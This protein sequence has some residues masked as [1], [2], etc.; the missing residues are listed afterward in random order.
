MIFMLIVFLKPCVRSCIVAYRELRHWTKNIIL[1]LCISSWV[2]FLSLGLSKLRLCSANHRPGYWSNQPCDWPSTAWAYSEQE[3]ENRPWS[4]I[5][6]KHPL[7]LRLFSKLSLC[8]SHCICMLLY[9]QVYGL[10]SSMCTEAI[11]FGKDERANPFLTKAMF[12]QW[13]HTELDYF[14][15]S[16]HCCIVLMAKICDIMMQWIK[17]VPMHI[18]E[19]YAIVLETNQNCVISRCRN[20]YEMI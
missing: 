9:V 2:L 11:W 17:I 6:R 15:V 14:T 20:I 19:I 5:N 7:M 4:Y 18:F 10:Y 12:A 3:T 1:C 8:V 16:L 13:P